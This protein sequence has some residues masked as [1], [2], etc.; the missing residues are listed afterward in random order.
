M[1]TVLV[2]TNSYD[3]AHVNAVAKHIISSGDKIFRVDTDKLLKGEQCVAWDYQSSSCTIRSERESFDLF[4]ASAVWF[5]KPFGFGSKHGFAESIKDPVQRRVVEREVHDIVDGVCLVLSSKR[6]V[7][8]PKD[9][10]L[11][12]LKP[13]QLQLARSIGL[14]VPDSIITN[15]PIEAR[16]FCGQSATVFKM[17][18]SQSL[19]YGDA[20]YYVGKTLMTDELIGKLDFIRSQPI[21]PQR[22]INKV[23]EL[24]VTY[25]GGK[26]FAAR[27]TVFANTSAIDWRSLQ[28]TRYSVYEP[29]SIPTRLIAQIRSLMK[30]LN[31]EFAAIDFAVDC[32][33]TLWFLEVNPNGQWLGYTDEIGLP[34]AFAMARLL[35]P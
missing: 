25:I 22:C 6:W 15:D 29:Y 12:R 2:L 10:S 3:D 30:S 9:M 17:L 18:S 7:N 31:L 24:R 32:D 35:A 11:A 21:L 27:Q 34:A 33:E 20:A 14:A 4:D 19:E 16:A 13:F 8:H 28:N 23:A 26:V 1:S 5:R